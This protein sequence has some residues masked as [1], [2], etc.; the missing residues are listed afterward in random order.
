MPLKELKFE[1]LEGV[2][3]LKIVESNMMIVGSSRIRVLIVEMNKKFRKDLAKRLNQFGYKTFEAENSTDTER[4]IKQK[5]IDVV[6]LGIN[7]FGRGGLSILEMIGEK[8]PSA[9]VILLNDSENIFLSIAGMKLGA[10]DDL[11]LPVDLEALR[12]RI[13]EAYQKKKEEQK[14]K[15]SLSRRC[16]DLMVAATFAEAG[17]DKTALEILRNK[18]RRNNR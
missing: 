2:L 13:E 1:E 5:K 3:N 4:I 15:L 16:Q 8:S 18:K 12:K 17:D 6:V 10:F 11:L 9:K 14:A 7:R